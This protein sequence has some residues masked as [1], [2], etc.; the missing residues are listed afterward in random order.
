MVQI[1]LLKFLQMQTSVLETKSEHIILYSYRWLIDELSPII[2]YR[3][4][5]CLTYGG[6]ISVML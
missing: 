4:Y 5:L 1:I 2:R 3:E 6:L